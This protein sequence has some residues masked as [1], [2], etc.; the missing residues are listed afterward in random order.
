MFRY[1]AFL[2]LGFIIGC[3][4][5]HVVAA[6]QLDRM[7]WQKEELKV[8]LYETTQKLNKLEEGCY[9]PVVTVKDIKLELYKEGGP[10]SYPPLHQ[11]LYEIAEELLGTEVTSLNHRFLYRMFDNRIIPLENQHYRIRVQAIVI[12]EQITFFLEVSLYEN[13]NAVA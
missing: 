8:K 6:K 13:L 2:L 11:S 1:F 12:G 7:Y 4:S 5:M 9:T 10:F 3:I